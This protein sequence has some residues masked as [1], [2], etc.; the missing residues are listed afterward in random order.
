MKDRDFWLLETVVISQARP[1]RRPLVARQ[2]E[3]RIRR[4]ADRAE[5]TRLKA[6]LF[7]VDYSYGVPSA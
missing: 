5:R 7:A 1:Q 3:K 6:L 2:L 4:C